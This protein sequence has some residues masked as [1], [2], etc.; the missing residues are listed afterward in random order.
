MIDFHPLAA[1][2]PM[3]DDDELDE[4]AADIRRNGLLEPIAVYDGLILDG[5]NRYLA[6]QAA[7][8][9]PRY[10]EFSGTDALAHVV[11]KNLHRRHLTSS[12]RAVIALDVLPELERQAKERQIATLKQGDTLPVPEQIPERADGEA[13][14]QAAALFRTNPHYV[15]DAKRMTTEAPDLLEQVRDGELSIPKAREEMAQR[16]GKPHVANNSGENEWYTPGGYLSAARHVMGGIDLDPASS[17]IAN[18][19]VQA[20]TYYTKEDDGLAQPWFGRVWMNPPYSQPLVTDFAYKLA[21]CYEDGEIEQAC[22][23]VNNATE[24]N[25]FQVMLRVSTAVCFIKGRVRFLDVEGNATGAPL[26]GQAVL[27]FG[28]NRDGFLSAFE[29]IGVVLHV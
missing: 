14:E 28:P 3:L 1:M 6:C 17:D 23:L 2:F 18:E 9:E 4:L 24:T 7:G 5:R 19:R 11:S 12:Q 25:W 27:Y 13:R 16:N 20:T 8:V 10:V 15:Q 29:H 22:V 21:A 26:Q